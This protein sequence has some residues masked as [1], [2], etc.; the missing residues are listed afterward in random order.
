[1]MQWSDDSLSSDDELLA[2]H[3]I[4]MMT[5]IYNMG[6]DEVQVV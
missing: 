3:R 2:S 6:A 5:P 4:R 1:M